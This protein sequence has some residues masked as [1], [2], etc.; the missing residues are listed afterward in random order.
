MHALGHQLGSSK[1]TGGPDGDPFRERVHIQHVRSIGRA[2][3]LQPPPLADR[4]LVIGLVRADDGA[5]GIDDV[6]RFH[7][8]RLQLLDDVGIAA[9]RHEADVLAVLLVGDREP[10]LPRQLAGLRL[11]HVAER[12]AEIV[13]LVLSGG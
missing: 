11:A 9:G 4:E 3:H 5:L 10:E 8:V 1:G 13:Q 12:E 2:S 6:A 7:C